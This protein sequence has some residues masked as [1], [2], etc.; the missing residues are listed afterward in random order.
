MDKYCYTCVVILT[1][2]WLNKQALSTKQC[3]ITEVQ[4]RVAL[5]I[6]VGPLCL[7]KISAHISLQ[8]NLILSYNN[9]F[10]MEPFPLN[11]P[12]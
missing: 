5:E 2:E 6:G 8:L 1:R 10:P 3:G 12:Q 4:K 11:K 7:L 9:P